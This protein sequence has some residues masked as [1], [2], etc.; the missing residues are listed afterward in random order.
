MTSGEIDKEY[1]RLHSEGFFKGKS[2]FQHAKS[3]KK[4]IDDTKSTTI[5]DFGSGKGQQYTVDKLDFFW[6]AKV[7]CYDPYV[8][9]YKNLPNKKF[10]GIICTD[11]LEHI[12]E[13]SISLV[14]EEIKRRA[15]KFIFLGICTRPAKKKFSNGTNL[16]LTVKPID[17]WRKM[18]YVEHLILK[19]E[20]SL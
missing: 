12:P 8:E 4:I 20:E 5:L 10:D 7:S 19:I 17:W 3:I 9:K 15:N 11:V 14:F 18:F 1:L 2:C 13:E 6:G 16:H